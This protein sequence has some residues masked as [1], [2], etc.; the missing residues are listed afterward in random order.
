MEIGSNEIIKQA[1]IA[2]L[3]IAFISAHTVAAELADGRLATLDVEGLPIM[4]QWHVV[5]RADKRLLPAAAAMRDFLISLGAA[6]L[7]ALPSTPTVPA[8]PQRPRRP[9]PTTSR[10]RAAAQA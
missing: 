5:K 7:P 2:G 8:R 1:V 9:K 3:G 10:R 4:R 6:M